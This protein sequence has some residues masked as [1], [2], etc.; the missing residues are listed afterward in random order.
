MSDCLLSALGID[1]DVKVAVLVMGS[2]ESTDVS[3]ATSV[4]EVV[5]AYCRRSVSTSTSTVPSR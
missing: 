1:F 2:F 4:G 5:G 3:Q